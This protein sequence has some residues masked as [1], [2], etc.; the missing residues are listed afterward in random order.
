MALTDTIKSLRNLLDQVCLD[1]NKASEKGNKAAS[2]RVRTGTIR[3]EKIA[4]LYRKES[5]KAEKGQT[6]RKKT[7]KKTAKKAAPKKSATKK[8]TTKKVVKKATAK[9]TTKRAAPKA[10]TV[11]RARAMSF[12]RTTRKSTSRRARAR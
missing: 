7:A 1:L 4:K 11:A 2:Q 6:G 10:K 3:L 8:T 12:K 9:K 5:V